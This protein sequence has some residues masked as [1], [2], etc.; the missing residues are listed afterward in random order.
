MAGDL[1]KQGKIDAVITGADRIAANGDT[2]NKIGTYSLSM[3]AKAHNIPMYIAAPSST[4]DPNIKSG[5]QINIEH[6]HAD[7]VR[8]FS[9]ISISPKD[10][11][12]YNPAFDVTP[13]RNI[14][15]IITERG[16]I[17]KPTPEKIARHLGD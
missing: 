7:E 1:M 17:E 5:E 9:G 13:A 3:L 8:G 10:V 11:A 15:A 2:A 4:F 16:V 6:R 14:T 12:V